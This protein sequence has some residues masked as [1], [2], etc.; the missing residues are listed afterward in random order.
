M[1]DN[2]NIVYKLTI[3]VTMILVLYIKNFVN[4]VNTYVKPIHIYFFALSK[5]RIY[6]INSRF[7]RL[8]MKFYFYILFYSFKKH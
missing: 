7:K 1:A 6:L 3:I 4:K 8:D 5:T 2:E